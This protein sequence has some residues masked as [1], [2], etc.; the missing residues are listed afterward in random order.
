[1]TEADLVKGCL[2][3][4]HD[5]Q[6]QLFDRYSGRMMSVCLRFAGEQYEAAEILQLGFI[7]VFENIH[8]FKGTGSLEGWIRRVIVTVAIRYLSKTKLPT[9][10]ITD[11][12]DTTTVDPDILSKISSDDIHGFIRKLPDGYR[13]VFNLNIIEGYSHD[14]IADMLG[15]QAT[16]S[17]TQLLKARKM[18]QSLILKQYNTVSI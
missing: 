11:E 7:K 4:K 3:K 12:D 2:R 13:L 15:I 5:C 10:S 17:R 6:K 1:L 8:Q 16:T 9:T 18:L 14:E